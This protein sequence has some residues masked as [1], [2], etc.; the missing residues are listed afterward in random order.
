MVRYHQETVRRWLQ[1][2][3]RGGVASLHDVPRSGAP[4][5]VT[6]E[7]REALH[8]L[9]QRTPG[10]LGLPFAHWTARRAADH[11]GAVLGVTVSPASVYRLMRQFGTADGSADGPAE[12]HTTSE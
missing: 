7:Y 8:G 10:E 12:N 11:L 3:L 5:R 4:L 9:I 1:R 6:A 2:Y